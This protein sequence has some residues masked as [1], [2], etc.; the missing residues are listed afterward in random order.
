MGAY[1]LTPLVGVFV[2]SMVAAG[3]TPASVANLLYST[4]QKYASAQLQDDPIL[5]N[6]SRVREI[7]DYAF[8]AEEYTMDEYD[9][10][11]A[12]VPTGLSDYQIRT[13]LSEFIDRTDYYAAE[14][15]IEE[16]FSIEVPA[17]VSFPAPTTPTSTTTTTTDTSTTVPTSI[18][19]TT[20]VAT[21]TETTTSSI[22]TEINTSLIVGL[23]IGGAISVLMILVFLKKY[24]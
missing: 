13:T 10:L 12:S 16:S 6:T 22:S 7:Q 11:M 3:E 8:F 21:S 9:R 17:S 24:Q 14:V 5:L 1:G 18:T 4:T 2:P 20:S 15:F 23:S 19:D